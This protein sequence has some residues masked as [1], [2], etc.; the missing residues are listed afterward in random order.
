MVVGFHWLL[1]PSHRPLFQELLRLQL[2]HLICFGIRKSLRYK[3]IRSDYEGDTSSDKAVS[4]IDGYLNYT[5][6]QAYASEKS[7]N[8]IVQ[9]LLE[10]VKN[11][12]CNLFPNK[13]IQMYEDINEM[14]DGDIDV[15]KK[16]YNQVGRFYDMYHNTLVKLNHLEASLVDDEPGPL[17]IPDSAVEYNGHYYYLCCNNEAEDYATAENYCKEQ[18]GYL[19]TIT[20]EKE[21]KFLFNYVRKKGYSSAYFGLNNLKDGKAY[22]WNN[23][24]LLIYTKWAKNEP[25]NT[26]SDYGYYVRFNENAKDGTWKVDTFSGGETNFNNVFLCEW[27][28]YSVTG[29][30]GLKVT[31][32][33]RDIVLTLD[34]SASMDGIPLDETKKAA[35]KFVD[36]ILNKNS[37]IGLVSYSDE[38][39]SLSGICSNDV[40]LKN[41]ITSLSSAENTN[42]EDG[43]SRAYSML[44]LG[45]SKK[46]LIVLMS[47]GLPTLGKDGEELIKYAEKIKDQGVLIYTLGFFQNTEEYKAEGQYLMEKIASEGCHYEVSSSEDLVFFFEDVA[48][49]IGG[50]KYIY[51]KVACPVDVS[52]TYKGE[53]LSSA[54]NDQNLRTSFGTLSFRENEGKENNEEESSGYSKTYLKEA[55]SKVKILRLKEGTDYNI[56]INGTGD[57]EMDYTIGFVNDEGEYNDLRRFEDI[58][59][60]KDTVID[61]VANTSKKTLL[62]ID[63]DGDGKYDLKLQAGVNGYGEEVKIDRGIYIILAYAFISALIITIIV[64]K[65][66]I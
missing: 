54:E 26:F 65:I 33:K 48:G 37:N 49:Q 8:Y 22:Q 60:N 29:N 6:Y 28:D 12:V 7:K 17:N 38:A 35:A 55:D 50:Q 58:D 64:R 62:N 56:K 9:T 13:H 30:D 46:K 63:E 51:V 21:N 34:I 44:Q 5:N 1:C 39:T 24:E 11:K 36:S 4:L 16:Y 40:F 2:N 42:I 32:K 59:I 53:T 15:T 61:T 3:E 41:T 20:S 14:L 23:G 25:D 18:G 47:D 57:G 19:A 66:S 10:G 52:V 27:G 45:Q 43:L 31:S